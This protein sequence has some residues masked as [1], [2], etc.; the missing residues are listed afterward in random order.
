M[1][2]YLEVMLIAGFFLLPLVPVLLGFIYYIFDFSLSRR[3]GLTLIILVHLYILIPLQF[4]V[5]AYLM[6][7][8]SLLFMP[9]LFLVFGLPLDVL[10][11]IAFY[12]WG[13]SLRGILPR[14]GEGAAFSRGLAFARAEDDR[15]PPKGE[16]G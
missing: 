8:G 13:M 14:K 4:M 6:Y 15:H 11:F 5:H 2:G 7:H 9:L 1:S 10:V 16:S 3:V 12:S